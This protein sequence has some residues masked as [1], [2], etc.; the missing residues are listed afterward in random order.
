MLIVPILNVGGALNRSAYH[1][2]NQNG[3]IEHGFR[4]NARNLDLNRDFIKLDYRNTQSLVKVIRQW[5][6]HIFVDTHTSNGADYPYTLTLIN[7]HT[8][9]HEASQSGFFIDSTLLPFF[10]EGMES[11]PFDMCPYVWSKER[12]PEYGNPGLYG[13]S[14]VHLGLCQPVQYHRLYSGNPYV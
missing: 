12:S 4:G 3:P 1:R 7:S 14:Q 6:P 13:L 2:A 8:Q 10:F 9:R 11:S 5:D